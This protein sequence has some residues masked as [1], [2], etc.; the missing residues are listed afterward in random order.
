MITFTLLEA[1]HCTQAEWTA[2]EGGT[3]RPCEFPVLVGLIAHP[4]E[5]LVLFDTGYAGRYFELT[6]GFP[7]SLYGLTAPASFREEQGV[8]H[9][10]RARGFDPADVRTVILSHFH[11][12]H[13]AGAADFPRARYLYVRAAYEKLKALRGLDALRAAY[14]PGLLP[15][16]FEERARYVEELPMK[17]F[18]SELAPFKW[19]RDLFGDG[20][21]VIVDLPGHAPGH[22]GVLVAS[23]PQPVFLVADA[24]WMA[25]SYRE[26]KAAHWLGQLIYEDPLRARVTLLELHQLHRRHPNLLIVPSHCAEMRDRL[27]RG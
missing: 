11:A 24:C 21:V 3:D 8:A 10:L 16:D 6:A 4:R 23:E 1:G 18:P 26:N 15:T 12:D 9:Q 25:R 20:A 2:I 27:V 7:G 17:R 22:F 5:G 13:I 14:L 19:G